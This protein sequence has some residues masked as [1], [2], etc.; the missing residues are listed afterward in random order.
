M[1]SIVGIIVSL[2]LAVVLAGCATG[3]TQEDVD[4]AIADATEDSEAWFTTTLLDHVDKRDMTIKESLDELLEQADLMDQR[5]VAEMAD[6][7]A[8]SDQVVAFGESF[9]RL[10]ERQ[11]DAICHI[12]YTLLSLWMAVTH[13]ENYVGEGDAT[14]GEVNAYLDNGLAFNVY[15]HFSDACFYTDEGD[16]RLKPSPTP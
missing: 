4:R 12:D 11:V 9:V 5:S 15:N 7:K 8:Q 3:V 14:L 1:K 16:F 13:L 10:Y 6:L 2:G